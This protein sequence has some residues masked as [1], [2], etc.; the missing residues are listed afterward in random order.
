[1]KIKQLLKKKRLVLDGALGTELENHLPKDSPIQ[2]KGNPLWSGMVLLK[3]P[4]LVEQVHSNYLDSGADIIT[5]STYQISYAS[6][7]KYTNLNDKEILDLW[8]KSIDVAQEAIRKSGKSKK[9]IVGSVGP[10]ATYL[11]NFSEYTGD[12][13]DAS[14]GDLEK[15]HLPMIKFF[16]EN[17]KVDVIGFETMPRFNEVKVVINIMKR[18]NIKKE[19]YVSINCIKVGEMVD[20]TPIQE[21]VTC[22][23]K[24]LRD[25]KYFIGLGINC[26][27]FDLINEII[28]EIDGL[29]LI[30]YPNFPF[31]DPDIDHSGWKQEVFK[32]LEFKNVR[33]I[34]GCCNTGPAEIRQIS[35]LVN[36]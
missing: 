12:Y 5:T 28:S 36:K 13:G 19:F 14:N 7:R 10:Y 20:G 17:K 27:H 2:P 34:G 26:T 24:E 35:E 8:N 32:W 3:D 1:M 33:I 31:E 16:V 23:Q 25:N 22:L 4:K 29:P 11:C 30:L 9:V 21:L 18:L 6:L 15:H